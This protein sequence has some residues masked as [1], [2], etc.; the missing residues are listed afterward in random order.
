[1]IT[2]G[3]NST[4]QEFIANGIQVVEGES[5]FGTDNA[6]VPNEHNCVG[7]WQ[8]QLHS[9][10]DKG[11]TLAKANNLVESTK[12]AKQIYNA[13]GQWGAEGGGGNP[14][15][16]YTGDYEPWM[17]DAKRAIELGPFDDGNTNPQGNPDNPGGPTNPSRGD[18]GR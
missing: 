18:F 6:W 15:A 5:S 7:Y 8:I 12:I 17:E 4:D 16:A 2:V 14:W 11:A 10:T 1:M 13:A 9:H 3:W